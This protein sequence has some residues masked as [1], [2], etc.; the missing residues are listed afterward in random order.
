MFRNKFI[1]NCS[2]YGQDVGYHDRFNTSG[3]SVITTARVFKL[4]INSCAFAFL[5]VIYL[6]S[7]FKNIFHEWYLLGDEDD[8]NLFPFI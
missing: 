6:K 1:Y 5:I 8:T 4:L 2:T 3:M 7:F